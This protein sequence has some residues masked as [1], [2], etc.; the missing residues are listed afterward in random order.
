MTEDA[1]KA[2][3]AHERL[4][5][6][7]SVVH[8][9]LPAI[10]F[11]TEILWLIVGLPMLISTGFVLSIMRHASKGKQSDLIYTHWLLAW[12]RGRYLLLSYVVSLGLFLLGW[13]FLQLQADEVMRGI[14]LAV[15]GWFSLLPISL[16][17]V[18]LIIL[19]TA[20]LAQARQGK[21]PRQITWWFKA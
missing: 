18:V 14:Q 17:I 20:S 8:F 16:T 13:L 1:K 19:E 5:F 9:L 3:D 15:F 21:K 10:L 2:S 6:N 11:N 4:L 7:L 12:R